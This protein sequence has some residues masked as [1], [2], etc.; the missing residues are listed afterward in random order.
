M[1]VVG[2][3]GYVKTPRGLRP[4]STVWATHL[5]EQC[6]RRFYKNFLASKKKAFT[7]YAKQ[8]ESEDGKK[9][10]D[11][12]L[13]RI[14]KYCP[15]IRAIAHTQVLL[16]VLLLKNLT[17]FRATNAIVRLCYCILFLFKVPFLII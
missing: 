14:A 5:Q 16:I 3:I 7:K 12:K 13:K 11:E 9:S 2:L 8:M 4:L 1:V 15:V 10:F 6:R 17:N